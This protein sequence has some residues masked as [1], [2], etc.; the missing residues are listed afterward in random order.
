MF[1]PNENVSSLGAKPPSRD[2]GGGCWDCHAPV[3]RNDVNLKP[4]AKDAEKLLARSMHQLSL[5]E[6]DQA[7][8]DLHGVIDLVEESQEF[9]DAKLFDMDQAFEKVASNH[10]YSLA[11]SLSIKYVSDLRLQFL[12]A[13]SYNPENAVERL[14][15]FL[16]AKLE[17]WGERKLAKDLELDDFS[18]D[19]M[20]AFKSGYAMLLDEKDRSGRVV[21]YLGATED[22]SLDSRRRIF[23]YL[24]SLAAKDVENQKRGLVVIKSSIGQ[25]NFFA[26]RML[27]V[28]V[29]LNC[30]PIKL[31]GIHCCYDSPFVHGVINASTFIMKRKD[32]VRLRFHYG[33]L[34]EAFYNLMGYGIVG[35]I[36]VG[37]DG[38]IKREIMKQWIR[39]RLAEEGSQPQEIETVVPN[40]E[41]VLL[42]R[43]KKVQSFPGN[44]KFREEI[45]SNRHTYDM[46]S[47]F[48][49]S[50]MIEIVLRRVKDT[51]GRFLQH[52]ASGYFEVDDDVARKKISHAWRNLRASE[53]RAFVP[54]KE[55]SVPTH[56]KRNMNELLLFPNPIDDFSRTFSLKRTKF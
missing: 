22:V 6:R 46:S 16:E 54:L 52:G 30:I 48:E 24:C 10:P 40:P 4:R 21:L 50:V 51:G 18:E 7:L 15:R 37:N 43:G 26:E 34:L 9:L 45:E 36:P 55:G 44:L 53:T 39:R 8:H 29:L 12:R 3:A 42:G 19:D 23:F 38:K 35:I 47:K 49:K 25:R 41:D 1:Q 5:E 11:K 13:E 28:V 56:L 14:L 32:L 20:K 33:S 31:R 2:L 17:I 27:K